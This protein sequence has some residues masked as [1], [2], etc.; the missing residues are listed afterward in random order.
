MAL[1]YESKCSVALGQLMN[2][3][4]RRDVSIHGEDTIG[5]NDSQAAILGLLEHLLEQLHVQ[6]LVP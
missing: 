3:V 4:E 5:D 2:L 6:V 1:I